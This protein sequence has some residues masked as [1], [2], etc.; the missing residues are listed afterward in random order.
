[1]HFKQFMIINNIMFKSLHKFKPITFILVAVFF[2][3][4]CG[5]KKMDARKTPTNA[6]ERA[7]LNVKEGK[8]MALKNLVRGNSS[9]TYEFST[10]N[11]MWRASLEILDFIPL[12]TVDYSGGI[13]ITDW[14]TDQKNGDAIK[15]TLRFLSNEIQSGNL[16]VIVH[17]RK[18]D[19]KN[20][21]T[22]NIIDSKMIKHSRI[23]ELY[24]STCCSASIFKYF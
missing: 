3:S 1:M 19:Q 10:S 13:I 14:Y 24:C 4:S 17:Q 5:Y 21:C 20:N 6:L 8:G 16:K 9:T 11:P 23:P 7:K 15:I 18:C 12:V 22:T 2:L